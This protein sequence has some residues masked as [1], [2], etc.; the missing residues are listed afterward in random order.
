MN[1]HFNNLVNK[2]STKGI[3]IDT[4]IML[5]LFIG[6]FNQSIISKFKR[7]Q[8]YNS[9]DYEYL[10]KFI[11]LFKIVLTLPNI[12]TEVNSLSNQLD[13]KYKKSYY[14]FFSKSVQILDE[15]YIPSKIISKSEKFW[16]FGLTDTAIEILAY[17]N[18]LVLSSDASL[19]KYLYNKNIDAINFAHLMEYGWSN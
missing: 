9:D 17:D 15:R 1:E 12:L 7:T 6:N 8:A 13:K 10:V 4:N 2:Y 14:T 3:I 16:Q 18:Y 5:L 11:K 19:C